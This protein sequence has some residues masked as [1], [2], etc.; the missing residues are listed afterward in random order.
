MKI[1]FVS[2]GCDKNL[3]D[4]EHM[5]GS[6]SKKYE[7]IND[8]EEADIAV[9]N[10]CAFINDAKEE[11][12]NTIIELSGLKTENLKHLFITG[13][14][15][16]RYHED[17][18]GLIPEI[19]GFIGISAID[20]IVEDIDRVVEG[21]KVKDFPDINEPQNITAFRY[22]TPPY[23]SSY[24]KIAEGCDK[25]CTYCSIPSIRGAFRSIPMEELVDE[26]KYLADN[27]VSEIILIAQETTVYGTDLYGK[28]S[29]VELVEKISEIDGIKWIRLMYCYP[30][31]ID[32]ALID[33]LAKN[34]KVCHY[35]DIPIQH[36]SD[37][38]LQR[39]GRRTSRKDLVDIITKLRK[40]VPDI[41]LRTS[42]IAGFP[43]ETQE[44]FEDLL[45]FVKE[46]KFDR[47][48]V[49]AYSREEGTLAYKFKNQVPQKIKKERRNKIMEEQSKISEYKN[50]LMVDKV[51]TAIIDGFDPENEVYVGRL[52]KDAPDVDGVVFIKGDRNLMSGD[53]VDVLITDY[54]E[55]DL[56]GEIKE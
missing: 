20:R 49:F 42:L 16:Q 10:T 53:Y 15:S 12:I 18:E 36:S 30:E 6:L 32:D 14:L 3:V 38:I 56:I 52:Y 47:L 2:L 17:L 19:D 9:V 55:Y 21:E 26:A 8:P 39:M 37:L 31:E 43:G 5:L 51:F 45:A 34:K 25:N 50:S 29:L 22:M 11:S 28:K 1:Y 35:L 41:S 44:D 48:G 54:N 24:L 27:G 4:S 40:K 46:I 33:L 23:H 13:C 7:I